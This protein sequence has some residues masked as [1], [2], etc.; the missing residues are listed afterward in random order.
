[1][2][3]IKREQEII[4]FPR[5]ERAIA[6]SNDVVGSTPV[7]VLFAVVDQAF[8]PIHLLRATG[9]VQRDH[10]QAMGTKVQLAS[11]SLSKTAQLGTDTEQKPRQV[12]FHFVPGRIFLQAIISPQRSVLAR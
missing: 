6:Q 3:I 7:E 11:V 12:R 10:P 9:F 2:A 8:Q 1:M 4:P 5:Y